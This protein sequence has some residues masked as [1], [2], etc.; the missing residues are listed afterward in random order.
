MKF[1]RIFYCDPRLALERPLLLAAVIGE[2]LPFVLL[3]T[4]LCTYLDDEAFPPRPRTNLLCA[5]QLIIN[6]FGIDRERLARALGGLQ[7]HRAVQ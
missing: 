2:L 3:L 7:F 1:T 6:E 4:N 5:V